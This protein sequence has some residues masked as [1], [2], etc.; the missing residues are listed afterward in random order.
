MHGKGK[1]IFANGNYY[2]GEFRDGVFDGD[3][4]L[5]FKDK[6]SFKAKWVDGL[7][8]DVGFMFRK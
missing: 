5:Y 7:A 6:G 8:I 1:Y 3:G 2:E 4:T